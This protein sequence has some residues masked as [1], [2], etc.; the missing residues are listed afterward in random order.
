MKI[1]IYN[2]VMISLVMLTASC[3]FGRGKRIISETNN[4]VSIRIEYSGRII[5]T[6]DSTAVKSISPNGYLKFKV[7]G[8]QLEAGN[9]DGK[10]I[11]SFDGDD[12]TSTISDRNKPFV[13]DA[14]HEMMKRGHY[15]K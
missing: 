14:V 12:E 4:D 9:R 3:H 7:N 5:F 11:Y 10:I 13:A 1:R 2:A 15:R 8:K 6:E